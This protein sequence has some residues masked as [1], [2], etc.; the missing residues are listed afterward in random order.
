[1]VKFNKN[2]YTL[3]LLRCI[4]KGLI[5][6]KALQLNSGKEGLYD[7]RD[8]LGV[9]IAF[10]S[11]ILFALSFLAYGTS[12]KTFA[13]VLLIIYGVYIFL[14]MLRDKLSAVCAICI[15]IIPIFMCSS[16]VLAEPASAQSKCSKV[17]K[18]LEAPDD[19][20]YAYLK[21]WY[22]NNCGGN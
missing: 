12:D 6:Y 1:M 4:K 8:R 5:K 3:K 14:A 21:Y 13:T 2:S 9:S 10:L 20:D 15:F 18:K 7:Y 17:K 19:Y 22:K 16:V 11:F